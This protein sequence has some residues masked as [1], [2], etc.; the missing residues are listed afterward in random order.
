MSELQLNHDGQTLSLPIY[1]HRNSLYEELHTRPSPKIV[2]PCYVSHLALSRGEGD[3]KREYDLVVSLC[4]RF[5][6]NPPAE[7]ASCFYQGFGGFEFRWERHTE[8]STYTFIRTIDEQKEDEFALAFIPK[9]WLNQLPGELVVA[10]NIRIQDDELNEREQ[11][12]FFEG[13]RPVGSLVANGK[14]KALTSFRLHSD[15]FGRFLIVNKGLNAY[16]AGRLVQRILEL[17]TYRL[18]A[19]MGLPVAR[20]LS[21][22]VSLM[23]AQLAE[24]NQK[25]AE[26]QTEQDERALLKRLSLIAARVEQYRSDTNYRFAATNAYHALVGKRLEQVYEQRISGLQTLREFLERRLTPGIRTC[27]SVRDRLEDLSRRIH[28]TTS[29]L[30]TRVEISIESQNHKLLASMDRR[31]G[32]QLRLQQTVEGLSVVAISYYLLS[33]LVYGFEGMAQYGLHINPKV[34]A[35]AAMPLVL[36]TV[37]WGVRRHIK[38]IAKKPRSRAKP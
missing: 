10:L 19:L 21:S 11:A 17:D 35:G 27:N 5:S 9:D 36:L 32:L 33:L 30:R 31:S 38:K 24:I 14:A 28:R 18:T 26:I 1:Q 16:Q 2:T 37:Y 6:V 20:G 25:I 34:A 4:Q 7:G 8:F 12:H 22:D 29:L 13:Q 23:E 15:G 3:V